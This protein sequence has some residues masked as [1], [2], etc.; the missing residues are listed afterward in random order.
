MQDPKL[1]VQLLACS[2]CGARCDSQDKPTCDCQRDW[3]RV[4]RHE[5]HAIVAFF[6]LIAVLVVGL[7]CR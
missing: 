4:R 7:L 2:A 5:L 1:T 3:D 6:G